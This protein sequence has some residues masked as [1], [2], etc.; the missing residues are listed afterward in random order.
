MNRTIRPTNRTILTSTLLLA[1]AIAAA[2]CGKKKEAGA[3]P[4]AAKEVPA[5]AAPAAGEAEKAVAA[6]A[7][8][9]VPAAAAA[10]EEEEAE[11]PK[12]FTPAA[13][14]QDVGLPADV[15]SLSLEELFT[16]QIPKG[17]KI[18][19]EETSDR[20]K[21]WRSLTAGD[22]TMSLRVHSP[23]QDEGPSC[24]AIADVKASLKGA[25]ILRDQ[26]FLVETEG[27]SFPFG[28]TI[29]LLQW[30]SGGKYG[31][32]AIKN[33]DFGDDSANFCCV[34]GAPSTADARSTLVDQAQ[35]QAMT[36]ICMSGA[37]KG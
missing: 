7:A 22:L 2:G 14:L 13:F 25:K 11:E 29:Q 37:F 5:V 31:F 12:A 15:A 1:A 19:K 36:G 27:S 23:E 30:E 26:A 24:P 20:T 28:D 9:A 17:A 18:S 4:T 32:Y 8:A 3:A 33:F 34:V 16:I 21:P 35:M 6:P 10:D